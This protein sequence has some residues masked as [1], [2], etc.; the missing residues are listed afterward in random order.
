MQ[1][2]KTIEQLSKK[3]Q[4]DIK[5]QE[6][7]KLEEFERRKKRFGKLAWRVGV[8]SFV[9]VIFILIFWYISGRPE[10]SD[11]EVVSRNGIHWHVN[12]AIYIKGE[13][14]EIPPNIGIGA[15]HQPIH[16][17]EDSDRG[18]IHLEF[19]GFARKSDLALGQFFKNWNKDFNSFGKLASMKVNGEEN[20][21]FE[22]YVMKDN[23]RIEI[24][25]E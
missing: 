1:E 20:T 9:A 24:K 10:I 6:K 21:E 15:V 22:N 25:Y 18:I 23:D 2:N 11:N 7:K 14:Q 19:Q 8:A 5:K 17:H 13:R 4:W 3:E 16:T 12:L